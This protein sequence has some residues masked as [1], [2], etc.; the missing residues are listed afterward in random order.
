MSQARNKNAEVNDVVYR[1]I[2]LIEKNGDSV[3]TDFKIVIDEDGDYVYSVEEPHC[4]FPGGCA[5]L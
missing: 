3:I 4:A 1:L 5:W 2:K